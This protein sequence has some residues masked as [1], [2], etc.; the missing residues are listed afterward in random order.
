LH[1]NWANSQPG[2]HSRTKGRTKIFPNL[3][4]S[5]ENPKAH[6][7]QIPMAPFDSVGVPASLMAGRVIG[8]VECPERAQRVEGLFMSASA[9]ADSR[10]VYIV[11]CTDG[12]LSVGDTS[13][14]NER[15]KVH[16]DGGGASWT[17]CRRPVVLV[18]Q[19]QHASEEKTIARERQIKRWSHNKK[20]ALIQ[21]DLAGLKS[22]A[23]RRVF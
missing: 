10:F 21:G 16:N 18:Y 14:V 17:A 15:V 9:S 12:S 13:N 20:L 2:F 19:E 1:I 11:R 8:R 3:Q 6:R 4:F 5:Y 22:L 7:V 23:K